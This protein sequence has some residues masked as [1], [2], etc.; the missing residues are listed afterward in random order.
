MVRL[1]TNLA[2]MF[3]KDAD[4]IFSLGCLGG[5]GDP[6][7]GVKLLRRPID[8]DGGADP[9]RY[10]VLAGA[11]RC[12]GRD[13]ESITAFQRFLELNPPDHRHVPE[14]YYGLGYQ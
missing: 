13:K 1:F 3:P 8:L 10:F 11:L 4:I 2:Q 6:A 5:M 12:S 7:E 14:S 9:S